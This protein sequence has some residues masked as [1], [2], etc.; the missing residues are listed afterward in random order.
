M[1]AALTKFPLQFFGDLARKDDPKIR[2]SRVRVKIA[3]VTSSGVSK[4]S[5]VNVRFRG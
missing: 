1:P 5:S 4:R 3:S 2:F